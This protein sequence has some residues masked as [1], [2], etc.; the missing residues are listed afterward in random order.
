M[1]QSGST[2]EVKVKSVAEKGFVTTEGQQFRISK[3][4]KQPIDLTL[5]QPG[6]T[7]KI[8]FFKGS[9]G[10]MLYMDQVT[11]VASSQTPDSGDLLHD[12]PVNGKV[13]ET[14]AD[15][16][17]PVN[18]DAVLESP[19][20][21]APTAVTSG[22]ESPAVASKGPSVEAT[23][24]KQAT[25]TERQTGIR[26]N[27][28]NQDKAEQDKARLEQDKARLEYSKSNDARIKKQALLNTAT[29]IMTNSGTDEDRSKLHPY[30]MTL[31]VMKI[32][33]LLDNCVEKG[34]AAGIEELQGTLNAMKKKGQGGEQPTAG[35]AQ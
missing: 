25:A 23:A 30:E 4:T 26:N 3:F 35:N 9:T 33:T 24:A 7:V 15:G 13:E 1:G 22:R 34:F 18:G 8:L 28:Y 16:S 14:T 17:L 29:A 32:A 2:A 11:K 20:G 12:A 31:R 10:D 27:W 21:K 19:A 6:D 5:I